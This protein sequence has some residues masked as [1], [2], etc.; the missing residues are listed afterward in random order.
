MKVKKNID[1]EYVISFTED[2]AKK[3]E[4]IESFFDISMDEVI[5]NVVD[6]YFET[7][8]ENI[9][10]MLGVLKRRLEE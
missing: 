2:E 1:G 10:T 3:V 4:E 8:G 7:A 5:Y 9:E 6:R